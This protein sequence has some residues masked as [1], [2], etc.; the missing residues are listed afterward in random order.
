MQVQEE[1]DQPIK[2]E[3]LSGHHQS[4]NSS[5]IPRTTQ[6][7]LPMKPLQ[8]EEGMMMEAPPQQNVI[9]QSLFAN[10]L[11]ALAMQHAAKLMANNTVEQQQQ[12]QFATYS[13]IVTT[14]SPSSNIASAVK[15]ASLGVQFGPGIN[16]NISNPNNNNGCLNG[17]GNG[18]IQQQNN[19]P[20]VNTGNNGPMCVQPGDW[21]CSKCGFVNWRRRRVCM[22]CY[23][24]ADQ[25][26]EM[27]RSIVNGAAVAAQ[28]AAG[29][30]PS[31]DLVASLTK[32]MTP[33]NGS[34]IPLYHN[35]S[36]PTPTPT[37]STTEY[38][39]LSYSFQNVSVSD[40]QHQQ[41]NPHFQ[42]SF[43]QTINNRPFY[44]VQPSPVHSPL[45]STK[46]SFESSPQS[47][48]RIELTRHAHSSSVLSSLN[49]FS[50]SF[51]AA[52]S[53]TNN[54]GFGG[55]FNEN[56]AAKSGGA[57]PIEED[58][59][60]FHGLWFGASGSK[61]KLTTTSTNNN[62]HQSIFNLPNQFSNKKIKIENNNNQDGKFEKI[63]VSAAN[64]KD[65]IVIPCANEKRYSFTPL[66]TTSSSNTATSAVGNGVNLQIENRL[67]PI[68]KAAIQPPTST[69]TTVTQKSS[70]KQHNRS[71]T[72]T[73]SSTTLK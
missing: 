8:S 70:P 15:L 24:L 55:G 41:W 48:N 59:I 21:V 54:N 23:P 31:A 44:S 26:N 30:E 52:T 66:T 42:T 58:Q 10:A 64:E 28:L 73:P 18:I 60:D 17:G 53:T 6:S 33:T 47:G 5:N 29:M 32:R 61:S 11:P 3:Y 12:A 25:N 13:P 39:A 65:E 40:H 7:S 37:K 22:R 35:N 38:D 45:I 50:T 62:T 20:I 68:C 56:K 27:S 14:S 51:T 34:Q 46:P 57:T 9:G 69:T 71:T 16:P 4:N 43:G 36:T 49:P 1:I 2:L 63:T 67:L 19:P 72:P